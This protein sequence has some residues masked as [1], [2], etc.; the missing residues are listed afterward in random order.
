MLPTPQNIYTWLSVTVGKLIN[1]HISKPDR[2]PPGVRLDH[3]NLAKYTQT[4]YL[5]QN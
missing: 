4:P 1:N 5:K 2:M 3:K